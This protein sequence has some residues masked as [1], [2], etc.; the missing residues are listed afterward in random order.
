MSNECGMVWLV[1]LLLTIVVEAFR[2][3]YGIPILELKC[4]FQTELV[5]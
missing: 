5:S 3:A 2:A 4:L 1:P